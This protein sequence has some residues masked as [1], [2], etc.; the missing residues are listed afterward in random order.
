M[1]LNEM[2]RNKR[3]KVLHSVQF[4]YFPVGKKEEKNRQ[5]T[6]AARMEKSVL[7]ICNFSV[8]IEESRRDLSCK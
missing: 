3:L 1:N 4:L 7:K 2:E 8:R 5:D 6:R